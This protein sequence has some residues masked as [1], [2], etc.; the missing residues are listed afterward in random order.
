MSD[1]K[2]PLILAQAAWL[3][4]HALTEQYQA[5]KLVGDDHTAERLFQ[6]AHDMLDVY[7]RL[8]GEA[9][10]ATRSIIEG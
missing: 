5:A 8:L 3:R 1:H 9:A 7:L 4:T 10:S 2:R 6:E